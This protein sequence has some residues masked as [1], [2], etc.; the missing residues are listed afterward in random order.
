MFVVVAGFEAAEFGAE[1]VPFG[2]EGHCLLGRDEGLAW[3]CGCVALAIGELECERNL[4]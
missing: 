3:M 4:Q 2:V 1:V